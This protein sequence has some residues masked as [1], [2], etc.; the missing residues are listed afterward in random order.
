M[1]PFLDKLNVIGMC[2]GL[3]FCVGGSLLRDRATSRSYWNLPTKM[4]M[5][6]GLRYWCTHIMMMILGY[7]IAM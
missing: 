4:S 6:V 3:E 7:V 1:F 2:I 5:I